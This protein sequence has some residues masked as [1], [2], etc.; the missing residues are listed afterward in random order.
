MVWG[1]KTSLE[2]KMSVTNEQ[3]KVLIKEV[4]SLR[5]R[6]DE[7]GGSNEELR[8]VNSHLEAAVVE[9]QKQL[10]AQKSKFEALL[11]EAS[12]GNRHE[13]VQ[14]KDTDTTS[15]LVQNALKASS[16][17]KHHKGYASSG[18]LDT[19]ELGESP[20]RSN[21]D[22]SPH[23][24]RPS[25]H[26]SLD[27]SSTFILPPPPL[28]VDLDGNAIEWDNDSREKMLQMDWLSPEQRAL[29]QDRQK[30]EL[31]FEDASHRRRSLA[32][33]T[34]HLFHLDK[35]E[36]PTEVESP[37][38][39]L[40]ESH[41][42]SKIS[43]RR[44]SAMFHT[45]SSDKTDH[46][47]TPTSVKLET[48]ISQDNPPETESIARTT[49]AAKP[50]CYR[51]GGTV[52]G[53]K[54]STCKC[55]IPQMTPIVEESAIDQFKGL[56]SKGKNAAKKAGSAVTSTLLK[57]RNDEG[58]S[59]DSHP[60]SMSPQTPNNTAATKKTTNLLSLDDPPSD[61]PPMPTSPSSPTHSEAS[62]QPSTS[63]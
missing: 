47:S 22:D 62:D 63:S 51:C 14:N 13:E 16:E 31:P 43:F 23:P 2:E 59:S 17:A 46:P 15:E 1:I 60:P 30:E 40:Q 28:P 38:D 42:E 54:Y 33:I 20:S 8:T 48:G 26:G 19:E 56:F 58:T 49:S 21:A 18:T 61:I 5:K 44:L 36:K 37:H 41:E 52:E 27:S 25:R 6:V 11:V 7:V 57:S 32:E 9:L 45:S 29:L 3:K 53:P 34:S 10:E 12:S 24:S 50:I 55:D 35:T 39:K 4:K